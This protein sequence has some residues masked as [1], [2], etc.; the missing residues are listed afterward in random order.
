MAAKRMTK[1]EF[2]GAIAKRS[3]LDKKQINASLEALNVVIYKELKSQHEV[4]IP[5]LLKLVTIKKPA[6][7]AHEGV[8]PFTGEKAMF[9][10]KPARTIVKARPV[11]ALKDAV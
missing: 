8:N 1:S 10:A 3:G 7:P 2:V 5:G 11:K 4:V 9:K 6:V